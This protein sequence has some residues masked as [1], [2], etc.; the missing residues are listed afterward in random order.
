MVCFLLASPA[1]A[2]AQYP[3]LGRSSTH[4]LCGM[5]VC[6][7]QSGSI[8]AHSSLPGYSCVQEAKGWKFKRPLGLCYPLVSLEQRQNRQ[9]KLPPWAIGTDFS[10]YLKSYPPLEAAPAGTILSSHIALIS[11]NLSFSISPP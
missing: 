11:C 3:A 10:S 8:Q 5:Y 2:P 6:A 1:S 4:G 7:E 9:K